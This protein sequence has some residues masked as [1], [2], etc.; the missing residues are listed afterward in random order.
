M[1]LSFGDKDLSLPIVQDE[2]PA[3]RLRL[4]VAGRTV[5]ATLRLAHSDGPVRVLLGR[6]T[7]SAAALVVDVREDD[8]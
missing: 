6:D 7:L 8:S 4:V 2:G 3:V 1:R 5:D